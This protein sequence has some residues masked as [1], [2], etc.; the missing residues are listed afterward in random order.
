MYIK[1]SENGKATICSKAER[2]L[3][4]YSKTR[5]IVD[6]LPKNL[7]KLK[8]RVETVPDIPQ[9]KNVIER[10]DDKREEYNPSENIT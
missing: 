10:T 1:L 6:N 9:K 2:D 7:Q 5:N 8:F 4:E 3:F